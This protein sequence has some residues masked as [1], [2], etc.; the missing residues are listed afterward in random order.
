MTISCALSR[1]GW[2]NLSHLAI[3]SPPV[4]AK[5][6]VNIISGDQHEDL[7]GEEPAFAPSKIVWISVESSSRNFIVWLS[8]NLCNSTITWSVIFNSECTRNRREWQETV[9]KGGSWRWE[10]EGQ[11]WKRREEQNGKGVDE[12]RQKGK[13]AIYAPSNQKWWIHPWWLTGKAA[14]RWLQY[15]ISNIQMFPPVKHSLGS[16]VVDVKIIGRSCGVERVCKIFKLQVYNI[17]LQTSTYI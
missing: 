11:E 12:R 2:L 6:Q 10:E 15:T 14:K 17:T 1:L 8:G 16:K 4:T 13:S 7:E 9:E 3:L 5:Q